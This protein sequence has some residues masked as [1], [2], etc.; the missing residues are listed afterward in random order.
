MAACF[1][2]GLTHDSEPLEPGAPPKWI[3]RTEVVYRRDPASAPVIDPETAFA[4]RCEKAAES[5]ERAE[6]MRAMELYQLA[7]RLRDGRMSLA[8]ATVK[9]EALR[10]SADDVEGDTDDENEAGR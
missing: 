2:H 8:A 9:F 10:R 7:Q 5:Y 6:P 1:Y 4:R 3:F